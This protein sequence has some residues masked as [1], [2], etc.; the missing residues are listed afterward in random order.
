[1]ILDRKNKKNLLRKNILCSIDNYKIS[2][3]GLLIISDLKYI[4]FKSYIWLFKSIYNNI[5]NLSIIPNYMYNINLIELNNGKLTITDSYVKKKISII[6]NTLY[7]DTNYDKISSFGSSEIKYIKYKNKLICELNEKILF[8]FKKFI[9]D[10]PYLYEK[11]FS[12]IFS[13]RYNYNNSKTIIGISLDYEFLKL[14]LISSH[15][16]FESIIEKYKTNKELKRFLI[17]YT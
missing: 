16:S 2:L 9:I 11:V 8:I 13:N 7:L 4:P 15:K 12:K 5:L 10:K 3:D 17:N 6:E 14:T 1:L